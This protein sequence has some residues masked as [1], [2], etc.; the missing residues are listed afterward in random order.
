MIMTIGIVLLVISGFFSLIKPD[1]FAQYSLA[2]NGKT[3][4]LGIFCKMFFV[5]GILFVCAS[6]VL[7]AWRYLP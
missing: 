6:F 4:W 1:V 5:F 7:L 2:V 3:D